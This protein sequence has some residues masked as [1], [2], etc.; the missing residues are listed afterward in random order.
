MPIPKTA[1]LPQIKRVLIIRL[2][3]IGDVVHATPLSAALGEA[4]PHWEIS[5]LVEEMSAEVVTGNPYLKEVIVVPRKRWKQGSGNRLAILKERIALLTSLRSKQFDLT[6]DLQGYA[7]S[8]ILALATGAKYRIGWRRLRDGSQW[9][10]QAVPPRPESQ[11]RVEWFMDVAYALGLRGDRVQFPLSIPDHARRSLQAKLE[12]FGVDSQAPYLV[13]NLA[14]GNEVRRW[15]VERYTELVEALVTTYRYP[16]LLIGSA[17]D[18]ALNQALI[19]RVTKAHPTGLLPLINLAGETDLKELM[20]LL[21]PAFAHITG[22]TGSTHIAA[23]LGVPTISLYGPTD[24]SHAGAWGQEARTLCHREICIQGCGGKECA[25]PCER[26]KPALEAGE[27]AQVAACLDAITLKE[28]MDQLES[29]QNA[30][31]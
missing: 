20:A 12:A 31:P 11:H 1:N 23:A 18:H 10:S 9:V 19:E 14:T 25:H 22:D 27:P 30:S 5:W 8:G 29:L 17:K 15:G 7:K 13:L 21:E 24:P 6:I 2:S 28:V 3:S 4:F 16:L 26:K